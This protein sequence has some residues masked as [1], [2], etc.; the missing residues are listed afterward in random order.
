LALN[1]GSFLELGRDYC[2]D[3]FSTVVQREKSLVTVGLRG[4][5]DG[6]GVALCLFLVLVKGQGETKSDTQRS[7][8][9][10]VESTTIALACPGRKQS[11]RTLWRRVSQPELL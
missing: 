11:E 10:E 5:L 6:G 4:C 8:S 1:C 3:D 7:A 9:G 2:G